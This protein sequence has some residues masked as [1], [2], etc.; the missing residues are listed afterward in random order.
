VRA[1]T[2]ATRTLRLYPP[3]S[4][5]PR[6]SA[7]EATSTLAEL[8][9]TEPVIP[10][11][12]AREGFT[13]AGMPVA[14][15]GSAELADLLVAHGVA[16]LDILPGCTEDDLVTALAAVL[17]S[18]DALRE[19]GGFGA[20]LASAGV[21]TVR[22]SDVS[23]TTVDLEALTPDGDV[24]EFLRQ[25]ATDPDKLALW[26]Q[27]VVKG[28]PSAL[29]EGLS[30]IMA[31]AGAGDIQRLID[32]LSSAFL[33]QDADGRDA[34]MGLAAAGDHGLGGLLAGVFGSMAPTDIA[35]SLV[36]GLYGENMLSMSSMLTNL[37]I[38]RRL[39]NIM[40][41]VKPMLA[42]AGHSAKEL[43]FL[44][45]MLEVRAS[46]EAE[47]PLF[48][49]APDYAKV[50]QIADVSAN[51]LAAV[52]KEVQNSLSHVSARTVATMLSLLDQQED[53]DLYCK[54]LDGLV[55]VVPA[56]IEQRD[57]DLARRVIGDLLSRE[58]RT[59]LAWPELT[60]RLHAALGNATDRRA[61]GALLHAV[62]DDPSI[63]N[64][65]RDI[66][67]KCGEQS[68]TA[69]IEEA[70]S[71][72]DRDGLEPVEQIMGR[73]LVDMLI[74]FAPKAQ[75]FQLAPVTK[76]L[77][78]ESDPR[79]A[80]TLD[81]LV[82]RG[83][84]QSRR[85][86]AKGLGASSAPRALQLLAVLAR[87]TNAEVAISSIRAIGTSS[88]PGSASVL[89]KLL[90]DIDVDGKDFEAAREIIGALARS[91]DAGA[92]DVLSRLAGRKALI[93]RGRFTEVCALA[94]QALDSRK[95]GGAR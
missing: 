31:A 26:L 39:D 91:G 62:L 68:Q 38:G 80:Q 86:V 5:I 24:D 4:P 15:T 60:E 64:I 79:S 35:S 12:V 47:Q 22:V 88:V 59:D 33:S 94:K 40:A 70:L 11:T 46:T 52:R 28:D 78:A 37:P 74:A 57:L 84:A 51:E 42:Q 43:S 30:E 61:M 81:A 83:D 2:T 90:G 58:S 49:R 77:V 73:R 14:S 17:Q 95:K 34:V 72:R 82:R 16:E 10:L 19:R 9:M 1:L 45:H 36:G 87:D 27:S 3:S 44:E 69:L 53:F 41:E 71:V 75:W 55:S 32:S 66:V 29:G 92:S 93:K 8:L 20:V 6:Q 21:E 65:A 7:A 67:L 54:T 89:E 18:P 13:F 76:R 50:A 56:L 23:L 85:E 48:E 63:A 25:L